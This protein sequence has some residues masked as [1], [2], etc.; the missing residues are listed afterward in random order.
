M[1]LPTPI[2]FEWDEGNI[3]KNWKKHKVHYK[4]IEEIFFNKPIKIYRNIKHSKLETR[5]II[6]GITNRKRKFHVTFTI[7]NSR[8]RIVSARDQSKKERK[9]YEKK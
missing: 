8:I 4:E 9:I 6:L 1:K 7:R 2:K 3:D 5:L